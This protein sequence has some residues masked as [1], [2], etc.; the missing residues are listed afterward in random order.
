MAC[1]EHLCAECNK[2]WFDNRSGGACPKC[3]ST[4]VVHVFDEE[5]DR[6]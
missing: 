3:G 5:G 4:N 6:D 2:V 1:M